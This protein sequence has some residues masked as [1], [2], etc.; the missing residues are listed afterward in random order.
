MK[1]RARNT[2]STGTHN[3]KRGQIYDFCPKTFEGYFYKI[4]EERE[5]KEIEGDKIETT[6]AK[7]KVQRRKKK[8]K[9]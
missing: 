1:Y 6:A 2:F 5:E 9:K 7:P 3:F 8:N 4:E